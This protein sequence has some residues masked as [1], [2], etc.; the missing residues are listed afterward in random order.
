VL[1]AIVTGLAR[2][3]GPVGVVIVIAL[4]AFVFA[5]RGQ[6]MAIIIGGIV[7][8]ALFVAWLIGEA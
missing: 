3:W 4:E 5:P 2:Y 8:A 6:L 7:G 1:A